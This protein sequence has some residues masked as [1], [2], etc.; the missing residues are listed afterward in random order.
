M[1]DIFEQ[2]DMRL[3]RKADDNAVMAVERFRTAVFADPERMQRVVARLAGPALGS[4]VDITQPRSSH[5]ARLERETETI[6]S[7]LFT[8]DTSGGYDQ[9]AEFDAATENALD[10]DPQHQALIEE[11]LKRKNI[12]SHEGPMKVVMREDP[13]ANPSRD[14]VR[15]N[16]LRVFVG[17]AAA[18]SEAQQ[19]QEPVNALPSAS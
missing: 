13:N 16:R 8:G 19:I 3:I 14:M 17:R 2:P 9:R 4:T 10:A 1:G 12:A 11:S 15:W 6:V 18:W 7:D 5:E